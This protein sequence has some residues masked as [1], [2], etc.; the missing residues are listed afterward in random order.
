MRHGVYVPRAEWE[1]LG[2]AAR[3]LVRMRAA[4]PALPFGAVFSHDSAA[5]VL[6]IPRLSAWPSRVH[7]TLPSAAADSQRVG[8]TLHAGP[9]DLDGGAFH[10]VPFAAL[11]VTAVMQARRADFAEAVVV[12]DHAVRRGVDADAL[13]QLLDDG[14][15]W[16]T[17]RALEA[18]DVCD[19]AH[20]SVGESFAAARFRQLGIPPVVPQAEF[21]IGGSVHRVDFWMPSLGVV[22]EFDGRQKYEDASM[23]HG[24][25]G[26][27]ALWA[28]KLRE[29][30]LRA[31]PVVRGFIRV[32]WWHLVE[33]ERLRAL[34][35]VHGVPCR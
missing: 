32:T 9:V 21:V 13:R 6:G 10:G 18:L 26:A 4:A 28:E 5:A 25:T 7:A 22:V 20:E 14:P 27:D 24:R 1:A 29:D 30:Q 3:H 17:A 33:P 12:L 15:R 19:A 2:P 16:G 8:L 11:P 31:L 23:L 35:R 34:F